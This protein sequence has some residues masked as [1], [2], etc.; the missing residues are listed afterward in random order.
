MPGE[1]K[2]EIPI[3]FTPRELRKYQ[4]VIK[5]NFNNGLY[6]VDVTVQGQG[7]PLNLELKDPDQSFTNLGIVSVGQEVSRTV[8]LINR[9]LKSVKFCVV[10][11]NVKE[12][13][14]C[15]LSISPID[16]QQ[17]VLKPKESYPIEVK[18][19]PK[20]RI[21]PFEHEIMIQVEGID[22][23]RKLLTVSGVAHGIELRLMDE[24]AAFGN[25]VVDSRL[26]KYI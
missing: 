12:F 1:E 4:E 3:T 8:P 25:V 9:S 15:A 23:P 2:I 6:F 19:R 22:D 10:P 14:K 11:K 7:I 5:L 18:F 13:G 26:T 20:E 21:K 16:K 24:V 17:V